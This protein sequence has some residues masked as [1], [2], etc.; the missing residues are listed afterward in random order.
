MPIYPRIIEEISRHQWAV[1]DRTMDAILR[2]VDVGID[3]SDRPAF[4]SAQTDVKDT[5]IE[6]A[7]VLG[8]KPAGAYRYGK[9]IGAIGLVHV[10][11]PIVPRASFFTEASGLT[12]VQGLGADIAAMGED[13]S[14]A[15]IAMVFDSPG[16]AVTGISELAAQIRAVEKPISAYVFGMAASAAYWLASAADEIVSADTGVI[17]SIGVVTSMPTLKNGERVIIKSTQS[18]RKQADPATEEGRAQY[19]ELV[20]EMADVFIDAVATNRSTTRGNVLENYGQGGEYLARQAVDRGMIDRVS[21]FADYMRTLSAAGV[22]GKNDGRIAAESNLIDNGIQVLKYQNTGSPA[23]SGD[24]D[25][26]K[27]ASKMNLTEFLAQS[28]DA[29]KELEARIAA[30]R[31]SAVSAVRTEMR[32][33]A[34]IAAGDQYPAAIRGM[35]AAVLSGEKSLDALDGA[36]V[37]FDALTESKKSTE[38]VAASAALP[39]TPA[40]TTEKLSDDHV[41][42]TEADFRAAVA[43]SR[44]EVIK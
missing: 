33:A 21:T 1:T 6:A 30:E 12:S 22:I 8:E 35:A 23:T 15:K 29:T 24:S 37:A 43:R 17:G 39:T 38:A 44:G 10:D 7:S 4:H 19:Q 27:G 20:D 11:G 16:G 26:E 41:C 31:A 9:K 18:P 3:S 5:P 2:A 32:F 42:R 14:I 34:S 28:P 25:T 13:P 36:V 40:Q